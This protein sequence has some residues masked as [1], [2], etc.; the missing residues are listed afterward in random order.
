[1]DKQ[2]TD[3]VRELVADTLQMPKE[4]VK[5]DSTAES[6]PAWDSLN[7]LNIILA[8]EQDFDIALPPEEMERMTGIE[9][10]VTVIQKH[11]GT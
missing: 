3:R 9:S 1:M 7:H 6:L 5:D 10:I 2:L 11:S 4:Q 8:I